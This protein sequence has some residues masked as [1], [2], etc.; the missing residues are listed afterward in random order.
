[1]SRRSNG[2]QVDNVDISDSSHDSSDEGVFRKLKDQ[3]DAVLL[4]CNLG[5]QVRQEDVNSWSAAPLFHSSLSYIMKPWFKTE[6]IKETHRERKSELVVVVY[7]LS[8][9]EA[10]AREALSSGSVSST[11]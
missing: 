1:M 7:N 8:I 2:G 10:E 9:S 6:Q 4:T 11:E 5:T 3:P